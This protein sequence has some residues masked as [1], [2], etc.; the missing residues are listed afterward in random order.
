MNADIR[1]HHDDCRNPEILYLNQIDT[2]IGMISRHH[3]ISYT[4]QWLTSDE[5][6]IYMW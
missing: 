3:D 6:P 5:I 2:S 1:I 4:N